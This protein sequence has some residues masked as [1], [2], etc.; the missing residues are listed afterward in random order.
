[1]YVCAI[2]KAI[3]FNAQASNVGHDVE[4]VGIVCQ[5]SGNKHVVCSRWRPWTVKGWGIKQRVRIGRVVRHVHCRVAI[6]SRTIQVQHHDKRLLAGRKRTTE[7]PVVSS[8]RC[9]CCK[10]A[11]MQCMTEPT[12]EKNAKHDH[13]TG[14]HWCGPV[15]VHVRF[16]PRSASIN[17]RW[18][19]V[20]WQSHRPYQTMP[21]YHFPTIDT[22][23]YATL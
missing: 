14:M 22:L 9:A 2:R 19:S 15:L 1:M 7:H 6:D 23:Y 8:A 12:K 20:L 13:P 4:V 17:R 5:R 3:C 10:P 21:R 11:A 18:R 16:A